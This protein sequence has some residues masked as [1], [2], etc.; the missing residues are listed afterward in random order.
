MSYAV[1]ACN[2]VDKV[3]GA[4]AR[5]VG[6]R[7]AEATGGDLVCPVLLNRSPTHYEKTLTEDALIV[8]D[9][10]GTRCASKLATE[11]GAK[12]KQKVLVSKLAKASA[13]QLEASLLLGPEEMAFA[14]SI[15]AEIV[16]A[17]SAAAAPAAPAVAWDAPTDFLVVVFNKFEFRIPRQGYWFSENDT[18]ARVMGDRAR[19]G[20]SDYLQQQLT[21]IVYFDPPEVGAPV[22]QFGVL[23]EVESSKAIFEL[24]A[25]VSGTVVA[26]NEA[27]VAESPGLINEDPYGSG[28]LVEVELSAWAEDRELLLDGPAYADTLGPKAATY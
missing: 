19:V 18:W 11:A 20:I 22:E 7:V 2:G 21:D 26:V 27:V 5:E 14:E 24:I 6:L 28:W 16:A 4:L 12:P 9:G 10:C 13:V 23:G 17:L 3:E 1:L 8:V 25:P 15:V